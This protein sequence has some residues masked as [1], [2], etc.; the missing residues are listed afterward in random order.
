MGQKKESRNRGKYIEV[1]RISLKCSFQKIK[2]DYWI[3][4]V[5]NK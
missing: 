4:S 1:Y 2:M 3:N 5:F